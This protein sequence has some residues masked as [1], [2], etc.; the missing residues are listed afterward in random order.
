M[1]QETL[2]RLTYVCGYLVGVAAAVREDTAQVVST[3]D[4][5]EVIKHYD[6]LRQATER[7]KEAREA[8][9]QM[10]QRLSREQ[11][12]EVM[13][14]H[15]VRTITIEG[16]GR[17]SLT[18]RWSCSM[19]DKE[20]GYEWLRSTGN[21]ALITETV[22]AMTLAA[23]AKDLDATKGIELPSDIF[24]TSI[25]TYTSITKAGVTNEQR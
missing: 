12:P 3:R 16:V 14:E 22:N 11:V 24:K 5:I 10:E 19:L 2:E 4:H 6:Q 20:A 7:I 15:N 21:G 25:M 23:F 8:L 1:K 18:N 13:R 17:V 9:D